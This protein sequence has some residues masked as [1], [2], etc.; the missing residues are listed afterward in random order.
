MNRKIYLIRHGQTRWNKEQ[1]FRG[2]IDVDLDEVGIR[3]AKA[4]GEY[5]KD[6]EINCVYTSPLKRAKETAEIIVSYH[7]GLKVHVL[8]ELIDI[9]YGKWQGLSISDVSSRYKSLYKAWLDTPHLVK[10][11]DGETLNDVKRRAIKGFQ[12]ALAK[13]EDGSFIIVSHRVVNKV[14]ICALLGLG[15]SSFWQIKQDTG[16]INIFELS[17][18]RLVLSLLNETYH[19]KDIHKGEE[20]PDF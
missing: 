9:D 7:P 18:Q 13:S 11:P 2:R 16:C 19:L 8:K 20:L 10:F 17:S 4:I 14:L 12:S 5:I 6:E 1:I 15:I 3:E